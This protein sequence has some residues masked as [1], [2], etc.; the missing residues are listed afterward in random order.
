M[1]EIRPESIKTFIEDTSIKLPRFQ[2]KQTWDAKRNFEL[3][4]S[5]FKE[6]PMGVCILNIE[7]DRGRTTK[8]LLDGR[9]RRNA[10]TKMWE[11]P[12]NIYEWAKKWCSF[13]ANAQS[14][15]V[16]ER[17]RSKI[18]DYLEDE[19]LDLQDA[20]EPIDESQTENGS[21]DDGEPEASI[22]ASDS[23][24]TL[25]TIDLS[26]H[27]LDFLLEIL[28]LIHNK[29]TKHSGFTRPFDFTR[30]ISNLPYE[31]ITNGRSSLSSRKL[32]TFINEYRSVAIDDNLD[33]EDPV[34]F[35]D[36]MK[37]RFDLSVE[38]GNKLNIVISSNWDKILD[39]FRILDRI[40]ELIMQSKIGLIEVKEISATD[41]QKI[42][43]I[44]NSKGTKLNAVEVLSA[45]PS[46]NQVITNPT[47]AQTQAKNDLYSRIEIK[48]D[49]VVKWDLPATILS[50]LDGFETFIQLSKDSTSGLDKQL[51]QGFKLLSGNFEMGV[52]KEDVDRLGKNATLNWQRD[53]EQVVADLN[54]MTKLILGIE[55]FKYFKSWRA[56]ITE[57]LSDAIALNFVLLCYEDWS[58]K[59]K[60]IGSDTKAKQFQKNAVVLIDQLVYEY[61]TRQ[62]RGSSDSKIA[63]NIAAFPTQPSVIEPVLKDKWLSLLTEIFDS[64]AIASVKITQKTMTPILYHFYCLM[65]LQGPTTD[66]GIEVDHILPQ[67]LFNASTIPEKIHLQHNLFNLGLLPKNENVSKGANRLRFIEEQWLKDQIVKYEF[68]NE[69]DFDKYSDLNNWPD[70]KSERSEIFFEAFGSKRDSTLTN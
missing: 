17:F 15:E 38:D 35:Q 3:C 4:I 14:H 29:T 59:G 39:R 47:A 69:I 32:K 1:Y 31:Q 70:L 57:I 30:V 12:E 54:L 48:Y 19:E 46:W 7:Q 27:G 42:F 5:V 9:Q 24:G 11:D 41:A 50:R 66:Y 61:V 23:P 68:I 62:W 2:R 21:E 63:G 60:P 33:F 45:K 64:N 37:R 18:S 13:K 43:N 16:E 51:T 55:Y 22:P 25:E 52:R 26:K 36:F 49:G 10:L 67:A 40:Q 6:F 65:K 44:I 20:P 34:T 56:S 53:F 58:R 8:W 28:L